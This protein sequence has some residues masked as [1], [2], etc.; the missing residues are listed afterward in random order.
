MN[1]ENVWGKNLERCVDKFTPQG[2]E[3]FYLYLFSIFFCGC[4]QPKSASKRVQ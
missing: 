1:K 2:V 4:K 3:V